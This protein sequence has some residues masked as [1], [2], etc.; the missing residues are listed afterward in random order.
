MDSY[1]TPE[2]WDMP[3]YELPG[4]YGGGRLHPGG[5]HRAV[6]RRPHAGALHRLP[7]GRPH[8]RVGASWG[9]CWRWR[10]CS[11]DRNPD[12]SVGAAI[13][14]PQISF[15]FNFIFRAV[16]LPLTQRLAVCIV[17][18]AG[19][20]S[21][22]DGRGGV[23]TCFGGCGGISGP[24]ARCA[25]AQGEAGAPGQHPCGCAGGGPTPGR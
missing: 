25:P 16:M 23:W 5:V 10:N 21:S 18:A 12:N 3:G 14:R 15:N 24:G 2:P 11:T 9:S 22:L 20:I 1:V 8:L 4:H 13:S 7:P 6:R 17:Q 19:R